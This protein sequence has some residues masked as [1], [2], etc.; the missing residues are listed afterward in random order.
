MKHLEF[1]I[2]DLSKIVYI[3]EFLITVLSGLQFDEGGSGGIGAPSLSKEQLSLGT[4]GKCLKMSS[5]VSLARVRS[6]T[7]ILV[8]G[9]FKVFNLCPVRSA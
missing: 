8:K 3:L 1:L 5:A 9:L 7:I 4:S 2:C 6:D